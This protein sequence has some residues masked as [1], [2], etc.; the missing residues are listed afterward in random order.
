MKTLRQNVIL[1]GTL[2]FAPE[3]RYTNSGDALATFV[4]NTHTDGA[5]I[6]NAWGEVAEDLIER[7]MIER[8]GIHPYGSFRIRKFRNQ[9]GEPRTMVYFHVQRIEYND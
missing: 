7:D 4:I 3:L 5:V 1:D 6:C 2:A 9:D 8:Q